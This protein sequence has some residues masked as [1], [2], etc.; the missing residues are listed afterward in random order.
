MIRFHKEGYKI[1]VIAFILSITG[2][3]LAEKFIEIIWV[4]K[5]IQIVILAF[6]FIV[7]QF[8]RN[9]KRATNLNENTIIAPVDGKVVVIEEVEEPEYFKD[10][11]LQVSI[12]MSPIN[13][14]V[15]RYAMGGVVKYSKY[16]PGKYLVAWHPKA[17]TENERTTIVLDN[18]VFGEV[19]YRQIAGALAKR[20]V[21]YAEEGTEV[22][23]GADAGFIKFGSRVDLYLP[24]GTELTIK[25][26]DVV[27]GG[28]QVVAKK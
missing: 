16:H 9:P 2:I 6:L 14:H 23:Q 26:G 1:I 24:I 19:L 11:R 13:V 28:T 22:I 15:T 7:L 12:F 4:V 3:L 5:S 25:L 17:S 20:I 10:K 8:F 18:K 27:K 21:N